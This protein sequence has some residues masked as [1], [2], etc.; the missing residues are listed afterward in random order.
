MSIIANAQIGVPKGIKIGVSETIADTTELKILSGATVT[1]AELNYS[2][3]VT[4]AIQTQLSARR[5]STDSDSTYVKVIDIDSAAYYT[6]AE[7]DTMNL[8]RRVLS[9]N[10]Q[11]SH[12]GTTIQTVI[13]TDTI[14]GG[15]IGKN[16]SFHIQALWSC[17]NSAGFK[18]MTIKFNNVAVG[19]QSMSTALHN[20]GNWIIYN[21]NSLS[22]QISFSNASDSGG[23]F[24]I[25]ATEIPTLSTFDTSADII[26]TVSIYLAT[27]TDT[28]SLEAFEILASY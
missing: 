20:K 19:K 13:L 18:V 8:V 1:T 3:G 24:G 6:A 11:L 16:G 15:S 5:D 2:D 25:N 22:S 14:T 10:T 27:G 17:T 7:I 23:T 26:V 28:A 12:T 4:S 9:S 21:R